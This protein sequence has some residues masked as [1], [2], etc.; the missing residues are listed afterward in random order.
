M[1][2][3]LGFGLTFFDVFYTSPTSEELVPIEKVLKTLNGRTYVITPNVLEFVKK[4][5]NCDDNIT[6]ALL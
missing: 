2:H 4:Y 5:F 3:V 6:G 1:T